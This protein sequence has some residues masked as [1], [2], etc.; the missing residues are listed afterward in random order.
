MEPTHEGMLIQNKIKFP[1]HQIVWSP[2]SFSL[3]VVIPGN[4]VEIIKVRYTSKNPL[5]KFVSCI[6]IDERVEMLGAAWLAKGK[7]LFTSGRI[8]LDSYPFYQGIFH[9]WDAD[10]GDILTSQILN[11]YCGRLTPYKDEAESSWRFMLGFIYDV[12]ANTNYKYGSLVDCHIVNYESIIKECKDK[13]NINLSKSNYRIFFLSSE[14]DCFAFAVK[15]EVYNIIKTFKNY[16]SKITDI[17]YS[18]HKEKIADMYWIPNSN[19][20]LSIDR[21]SIAH[22]WDY[23]TGKTISA[24]HQLYDYTKLRVSPNGKYVAIVERRS[25]AIYVCDI[26]SGKSL[27]VYHDHPQRFFKVYEIA[28][29]PDCAYIAS[30]ANDG[31]IHIWQVVT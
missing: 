29:S 15:N 18:S 24:Y 12:W 25:N 16:N 19:N 17:K 23:L 6:D 22:V 7:Y 27:D 3:A 9:L 4:H 21:S 5:Q 2:D 13:L 8:H 20:I 14:L 30:A 28:W 31:Y 1:T 10:T 11:N 26:F